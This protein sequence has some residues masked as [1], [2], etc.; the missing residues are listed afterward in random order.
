MYKVD[1]IL[2]SFWGLHCNIACSV[3]L[4]KHCVKQTHAMACKTRKTGEP[5]EIP[6]NT[7]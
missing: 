5:G 3:Q 7:D 2:K 4:R 1:L 6:R